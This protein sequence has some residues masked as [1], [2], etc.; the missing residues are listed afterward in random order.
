MIKRRSFGER[1]VQG[2]FWIVSMTSPILRPA[3]AA[4][5]NFSWSFAFVVD[6]EGSWWVINKITALLIL[7]R[8]NRNEWIE[9]ILT[10]AE[11]S[12]AINNKAGISI[13][14]SISTASLG[15]STLDFWHACVGY[16]NKFERRHQGGDPLI[17]IFVGAIVPQMFGTRYLGI[18]MPLSSWRPTEKTI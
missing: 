16:T 11:R 18:P 2:L 7:R 3:R 9:S 4:V 12:I 17:V 13:N 5:Y 1:S 8:M 15:R 6:G 14:K 10:S